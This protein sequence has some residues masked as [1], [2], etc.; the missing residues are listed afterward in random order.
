MCASDNSIC[1][2][3][4]NPYGTFPMLSPLGNAYP[5]AEQL[6]T[7][8]SAYSTSTFHALRQPGK[9]TIILSAS[10]TLTTL[11]GLSG[12]ACIAGLVVILCFAASMVS[13]FTALSRYKTEMDQGS[14][15]QAEKA[16][17]SSPHALFHRRSV[18]LSLPLA[19]LTLRGSSPSAGV[20]IASAM[21]TKR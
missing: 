7:S 19:F 5:S 15:L 6:P 10:V 18:L 14:G 1:V 11:P 9:A 21:A 2:P 13:S 4:N 8:S 3:T 20:L 12:V 17:Y 16:L